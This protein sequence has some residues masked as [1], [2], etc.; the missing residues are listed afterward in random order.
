M[1]VYCSLIFC[2]VKVGAER[3]I[4]GD[5]SK[6]RAPTFMRSPVPVSDEVPSDDDDHKGKS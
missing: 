6:S 5:I 2:Q 4:D 3:A 1:I